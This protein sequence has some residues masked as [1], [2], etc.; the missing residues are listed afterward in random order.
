MLTGITSYIALKTKMAAEVVQA[1][2]DEVCGKFGDLQKA[3]LNNGTE[4]KNQL[5]TNVATQ[6]EVEHK[7]YSQH[8]INNQREELKGF[9]TF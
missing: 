8:I 1:Y 6:Q 7:I 4:F 5:F 9:I 2:V 3:S